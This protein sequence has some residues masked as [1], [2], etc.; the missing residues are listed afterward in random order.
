ML[1]C[2]CCCSA[3][4][5][6][7]ERVLLAHH[8]DKDLLRGE[9]RVA[10]GVARVHD[11]RVGLGGGGGQLGGAI[12]LEHRAPQQLE[13]AFPAMRRGIVRGVGK[14]AEGDSDSSAHGYSFLNFCVMSTTSAGILAGLTFALATR[15]VFILLASLISLTF[16]MNDMC[17]AARA[18]A[19]SRIAAD[20][21]GVC[22]AARAGTEVPIGCQAAR[23]AA[24]TANIGEC[25]D[26]DT[27]QKARVDLGPQT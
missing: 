27:E 26:T 15:T 2:G 12:Y 10:E 11:L 3:A 17:T 18:V 4:H 20:A 1:L 9:H 5:H 14:R 25:C 24:A 21:N 16:D 8:L 6:H 13:V 22:T 19:D 7:I 23:E